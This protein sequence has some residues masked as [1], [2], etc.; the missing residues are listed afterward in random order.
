[1]MELISL[2]IM[3]YYLGK[4]TST[5]VN[6]EYMSLKKKLIIF[7]MLVIIPIVI[8]IIIKFILDK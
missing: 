1:M 4:F 7:T 3:E 6:E 8:K 5:L 2:I